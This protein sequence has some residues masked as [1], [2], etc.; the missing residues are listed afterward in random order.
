MCNTTNNR[1]YIIVVHGMGEQ[2]TSD[3]APPV[4]E[5]IAAARRRKQ[6]SSDSDK[7]KH[8]GGVVLPASI[9][10]QTVRNDGKGHGW[11]EFDGIPVDPGEV[12]DAP[13]QG[14][15]AEDAYA[16][17]FRFVDLYWQYVLQSDIERYGSS[18]EAWSTALLN[19]LRILQQQGKKPAEWVFP[20]LTS[21]VNT[22]IPIKQMMVFRFSQA[23]KMIFDGFLGDV[24]L[25]GDYARSRGR[26][27]RQFHVVLDEIM[28][29]DF[30]Y[31]YWNNAGNTQNQKDLFKIYKPPDFTVLAHS[32]GS[33]MSFDALVYAF[34]NDGIRQNKPPRPLKCPSSL[35]FAG[36]EYV[37]KAEETNYSYLKAKLEQVIKHDESNTAFIQALQEGTSVLFH[38]KNQVQNKGVS[39][40]KLISW[41]KQIKNFI[42]LG[43]P[44]DKF[45]TLWPEN[46]NHFECDD[47]RD[48]LFE[49]PEKQNRIQHYN[50]C[51][52]QDPVGH[53]LEIAMDKT[54]YQDIFDAKPA[55]NH[56]VVFR[57][58]GL[59]GLAHIMYWKDQELFNGIMDRIIDADSPKPSTQN[60]FIW[61][62]IFKNSREKALKNAQRWAYFLIPFLAAL[63]STALVSYGCMA[64]HDLWRF[65]AF[66]GALLLWWQPAILTAYKKELDITDDAEGYPWPRWLTT[67]FA[68]LGKMRPVK[69]ILNRLIYAAI[70]WRRILIIESE[71]LNTDENNISM[72]IAYPNDKTV[73]TKYQKRLLLISVGWFAF[74]CILYAGLVLLGFPLGFKEL[75]SPAAISGWLPSIIIILRV[76][77]Y[78]AF[79]YALIRFYI[80]HLFRHV[81]NKSTG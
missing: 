18:T 30:L 59:P 26:A 77:F 38:G 56:D 2:K 28:I 51:D 31:W 48:T 63:V 45:L 24:H 49:P 6:T 65:A 11:V 72:R 66:L 74:A 50:F 33:I 69:G 32:L 23:S 61:N 44:I 80:W 16:K 68:R 36:Y 9:S 8:S 41:K 46:Y 75:F 71:G 53:H 60:S 40:D 47:I 67:L 78:L 22:A 4:I 25:Y 34:A 20:M 27:V 13:F 70:E 58:Y 12:P 21:I 17:N 37:D 55:G 62:D 7:Q 3:T 15:A 14:I 35:P 5:R 39:T 76:L 43:S 42:T 64:D 81:L 52:E 1:H 73:K 19:K 79:S 29:R 10:E 54:L 57:R